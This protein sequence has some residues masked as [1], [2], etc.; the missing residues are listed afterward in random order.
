MKTKRRRTT[1]KLG[2]GPTS[3]AA[4]NLLRH[5]TVHLEEAEWHARNGNCREAF[6]QFEDGVREQAEGM[7]EQRA[8]GAGNDD[9]GLSE[10]K[11]AARSRIKKSCLR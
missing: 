3:A 6:R 11:S 10:M 1:R 5:A 4:Q 9:H 2:A 7:A 8:S